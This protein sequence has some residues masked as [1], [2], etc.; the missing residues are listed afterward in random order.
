MAEP[1]IAEEVAESEFERFALEMDLDTNT[2]KMS[3]DRLAAF[4]E[5]RRVAVRALMRGSLVIDDGGQAVFTP[6]YDKDTKPLTFFASDGTVLSSM[7]KKKESE[8]VAKKYTAM[9]AITKT[10]AARF[11]AM[12]TRDLKVCQALYL[13]FLA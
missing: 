5:L 6:Q 1:K 11:N 7:D 9:G 10:S 8:P 3:E 12:D 2:E 13:L 4:T